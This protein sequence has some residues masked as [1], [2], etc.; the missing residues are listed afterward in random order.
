MVIRKDYYNEFS[1]NNSIKYFAFAERYMKGVGY[2]SETDLHFELNNDGI[3]KVIRNNDF[4]DKQ[5]M[6][7]KNKCVDCKLYSINNTLEAKVDD[8]KLK[9]LEE[10]LKQY[11][12]D[13]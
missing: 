5:Y 1:K 10:L 3:I 7:R 9:N 11:G 6:N 13:M 8:A 2:F 12:I 4:T